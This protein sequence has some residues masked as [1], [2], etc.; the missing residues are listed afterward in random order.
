MKRFSFLYSIFLTSL[1]VSSCDYAPPPRQY[2]LTYKNTAP[3]IKQAHFLGLSLAKSVLHASYH[4]ENK[5]L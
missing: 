4:S 3:L 5:V 2:I 1:C